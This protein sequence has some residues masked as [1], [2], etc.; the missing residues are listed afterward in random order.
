MQ[1]S[2]LDHVNLQGEFNYIK[3]K[4]LSHLTDL[5]EIMSSFGSEKGKGVHNYSVVYDWLFSRFRKDSLAIF[6]LGL[7]TNKVGAPSSM[8]PN[9]KPGASLQGWR[10]YFSIAK[11]YGVDIDADILFEEDRVRTYWT[12]QRDPNRREVG[13]E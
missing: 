10:E 13:H 7:G 2:L 4:G 5:C 6:E 12:D 3:A 11:I 8:G 1:K 9:G